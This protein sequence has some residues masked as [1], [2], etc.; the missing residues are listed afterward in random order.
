MIGY[1]GFSDSFNGIY[2]GLCHCF[3]LCIFAQLLL[4]YC[5][6]RSFYLSTFVAAVLLSGLVV[7]LFTQNPRFDLWPLLVSN[8]LFAVISLLSFT[9]IFRGLRSNNGHSL[10]RAKYIAMFLKFILCLGVLLGFIFWNGIDQLYKPAIFLILG[11]YVVYAAL[12][13]IPLSQMA[14]KR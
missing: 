7:F 5:M 9:L 13:A 12:E 3:F 6:R 10:L 14:K 1:K 8:F 11:M 4:D 2:L